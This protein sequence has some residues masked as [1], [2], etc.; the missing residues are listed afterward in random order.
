VTQ[1]KWANV[2][3]NNPMQVVQPPGDNSRLIQHAVEFNHNGGQVAF[4]LDGYPPAVARWSASARA[5]TASSMW[6]ATAPG[7][8]SRSSPDRAGAP[9]TSRPSSVPRAKPNRCQGCRGGGIRNPCVHGAAGSKGRA[10][11]GLLRQ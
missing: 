7:A 1:N 10:L 5:M 8:S 6:S 9:R 3:F 4:G 11:N 2:T